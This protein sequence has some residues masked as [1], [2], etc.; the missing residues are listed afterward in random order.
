MNTNE[1]TLW[2]KIVT[3]GALEPAET[4]WLHTNGAGAYAMSTLSLMHT[5]RYHG[6]LVAALDPPLERH[7]IV[8]HADTSVEVGRRAHSLSTHQFP[9]VAPTPGYRQ[10]TE[11]AQ[12]P[13][14]RWTYRLG[15]H[16]LER[17]LALVRGQNTVVISFTWHGRTPAVMTLKPLL[18]MRPIRHLRSEQEGLQQAV[19]LR[20]SG[21]GEVVVQPVET[22]P[23]VVFGYEGTFVGSPDWWRRFE[24]TLDQRREAH[25][26]EDL[27][28]PGTFE[29]VLQPGE[30]AYLTAGLGKLPTE[31]PQ[32][33]MNQTSQFLER[34]D[35]GPEYSSQ[36]RALHVAA[37]Q[38]RAAACPRPATLA[39]YPWLGVRT[40]DTLISLVG[41]YLVQGLVEEAKAALAT[42]LEHQSG[43]LLLG[44]VPESSAPHPAV[45]VDASLWL[46]EAARQLAPELK[47]G[48][49]FIQQRLMPVMTGIFDRVT[50]PIRTLVWLTDDGLLETRAHDEALTWMDAV[51]RGQLVTP[52]PGLAVE[53]QALWSRACDTLAKFA[54]ESDNQQLAHRAAAARDKTRSAFK[55]R[56]WCERTNYPFDH[57]DESAEQTLT[58]AIRPNALIALSL[59]PECF[60]TW[61]AQAIVD[62]VRKRLLT[63]AGLRTLD[64]E[65]PSYVGYYEGGMD[66]RRAAYHQGVVW[67]YL[68]GA[69][70]RAALQSQPD[71]FELEIEIRDNIL[72][73]LRNGLVLGQVAQIAGGDPPHPPGGCPAQA[74]T[75]AELLRTLRRD[76]SQ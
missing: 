11:F 42:C 69:Y 65:H 10:L 59:D 40:R 26:Q 72:S 2:P 4:E 51:A 34:L 73:A 20:R 74:W 67:G 56:F 32:D 1:S 31:S 9:D 22:L 18:S 33:L 60:E 3:A 44:G 49:D 52:R 5:R 23:E 25:Y 37:E 29:W 8:S 17:R 16:L 27:W 15:G 38:Y 68:L 61:Q 41:L 28:T 36:E 57:L 55:A 21:R 63:P 50:R 14:P 19:T 71:D 35:P 54:A 43:G 30:P 53:L 39:G 6:M 24:Y 48:D 12:D 47:P 46:F 75:V 70:A 58:A 62:H 64:P 76:L 66:A 45:S 13:L 7:V